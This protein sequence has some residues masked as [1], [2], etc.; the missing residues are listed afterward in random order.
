MIL[1]KLWYKVRGKEKEF[2]QK[3]YNQI[4]QGFDRITFPH[5]RQIIPEFKEKGC[6]IT[7]ATREQAKQ[8]MS[9]LSKGV[10]I[11]ERMCY[12][13]L[14]Q[15][16]TK[17]EKEIVINFFFF[18]GTPFIEDLKLKPSVFLK[19]TLSSNTEHFK[20]NTEMLFSELRQYGKIDSINV[21]EKLLSATIKFSNT[22]SSIAAKNCIHWKPIGDTQF[23]VRYVPFS[24]FQ[25]LFYYFFSFIHFFL[26]L[27]A[28]TST[29]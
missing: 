7:F 5:I 28:S 9:L 12:A 11:N 1:R 3:I 15:V 20:L 29:S 21:D 22:N 18:K 13:Y 2:Q 17:K 19:I 24:V 14:V 6:Y 27:L 10:K 16:T 8:S 26:Y 23:T 4:N 25:L